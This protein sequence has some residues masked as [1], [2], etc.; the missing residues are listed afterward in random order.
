M[1]IMCIRM[2]VIY[3]YTYILYL[4]IFYNTIIIL[5]SN[6][7]ESREHGDMKRSLCLVHVHGCSSHGCR[8]KSHP[9]VEVFYCSVILPYF[10]CKG[11]WLNLMQTFVDTE[12]M[13]HNETAILLVNDTAI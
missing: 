5:W 11:V 12:L 13:R 9:F 3:M 6:V 2:R 8:W 7:T 10:R 4:Y 1:Y